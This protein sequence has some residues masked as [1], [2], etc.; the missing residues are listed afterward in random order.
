MATGVL[1]AI[2]LSMADSGE[3]MATER[4][5]HDEYETQ[6]MSYEV[7]KLTNLIILPVPT[8]ASED[9]VAPVSNACGEGP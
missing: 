2:S 4:W 5:P 1:A 8:L 3:E 7:G 6:D 9:R